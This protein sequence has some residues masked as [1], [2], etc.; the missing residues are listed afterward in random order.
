[1]QSNLFIPKRIKV[2]FQEREETYT[3]KL[4]YIIYFDEKDKIRKEKSWLSWCDEK[5]GSF[6]FDN[7]P[8]SGYVFNKGVKRYA[9]HFGSGRSMLRVYDPRDFEFEI[10]IDNLEAVLM[11]SDISKKEILG[12]YVFAWSG[13]DLILLPTSSQE[14]IDSVSY[15]IKQDKKISAKE[16][17]KGATYSRKKNNEHYIY[18]GH[19]EWF[20]KENCGLNTQNISKGKKHIFAT[21][22]NDD[23]I[24]F[25]PVSPNL[26][27]ECLN[28]DSID[29]YPELVIQLEE[30]FNFKKINDFE[31]I[32]ITSGFLETENNSWQR[33]YLIRKES[34]TRYTYLYF[35]ENRTIKNPKDSHYGYDKYAI[36]HYDLINN[37]F[38]RLRQ[39]V[40]R[41]YGNAY[42]EVINDKDS[43]KELELAIFDTK[44]KFTPEEFVE[45]LKALN[46]KEFRVKREDGLLYP[47][48]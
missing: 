9:Y 21:I 30:S 28:E 23:K 45:K 15:T 39:N 18:M 25:Y 40:N 1:M 20:E 29:N 36:E 2:G 34:E 41:Y 19:Y 26:L 42:S 16:L 32:D 8:R 38:E 10:T 7:E 48:T 37:S 47:I 14:Y 12:E 33:R 6:E 11:N 43:E 13:S 27:A 22:D 4:A 44:D 35:Y 17:I 46:F 3:G 5:L 31:L 24:E